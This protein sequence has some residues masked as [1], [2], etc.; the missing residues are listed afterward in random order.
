MHGNAT[1]DEVLEMP[2]YSPAEAARYFHIAPSTLEYW[3]AGPRPLVRLASTRPKMLSF[4]NL[5]E[6]Y[7]L[8]GVRRQGLPLRS[9]RAAVE[10]L[11]KHEESNH[12]L[13]D[14]DLRTLNN[15]HLVLCS[16]NLGLNVSLGGQYEIM[17]WIVPYLR[18]VDRDP[19]GSAQKIFP[20]MTKSHISNVDTP[21]LSDARPPVFVLDYLSL[22]IQGLQLDLSQADIAAETL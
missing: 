17:A 15:R 3:A 13:A 22:L 21:A 19:G 20:Y 5:V 9:I 4:K 16:G 8:E 12:P 2:N 6:L 14:F 1:P 18:R 7:V 11:L 10:N